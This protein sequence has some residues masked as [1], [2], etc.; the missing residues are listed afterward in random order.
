MTTSATRSGFTLLEVVTVLAVIGAT[1]AIVAPRWPGWDHVPLDAVA[2]RL[3]E[4]ISAAR[5]E[6]ILAGDDRSLDLELPTTTGVAVS[7]VEIGGIPVALPA[8]VALGADGDPLP[9]RVTLADRS[10]HAL[11]VVVPPG[12]GRARV[13]P[14]GAS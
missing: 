1:A 7:R 10:G 6:A 13:E 3:A 4:R 2:W 9:V 14:E 11:V 8:R 12:F 5:T